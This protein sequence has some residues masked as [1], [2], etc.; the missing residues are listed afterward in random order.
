MIYGC[1]KLLKFWIKVNPNSGGRTGAPDKIRVGNRNSGGFLANGAV[2]DT[3]GVSVGSGVSRNVGA[4]PSVSEGRRA[5]GN[6]GS[7]GDSLA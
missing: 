1:L 5:S 7:P 2:A 6:I 4:A 3:E